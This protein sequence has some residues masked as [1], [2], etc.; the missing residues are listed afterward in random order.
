VLGAFFVYLLLDTFMKESDSQN[1]K[2]SDTAVLLILSSPFLII[3]II[4]CHSMYLTDM[5]YD[6][7]KQRKQDR[8]EYD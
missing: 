4:G 1:E 7:V 5:I 3:F 2:L 6:E 8:S